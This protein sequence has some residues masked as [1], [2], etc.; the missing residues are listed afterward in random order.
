VHRLHVE[1]INMT[2]V[3]ITGSMLRAAR[4]LTGLSQQEIAERASIS[5]PS[6]TVWEGSSNSVP[7]ANVRAL[8]RVV[9]VLEHAGVVFI[10]GGA[11]LQSRQPLPSITAQ[12]EARP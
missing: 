9:S 12:S 2:V 11:T 4:S 8:G 7:G 3:E 1:I 10:A 5:R 6:L